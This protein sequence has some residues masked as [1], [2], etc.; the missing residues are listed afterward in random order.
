MSAYIT[1]SFTPTD[2]EKLAEYG[3][4]APAT[5][6]K[7]GGEFL[8]KGAAE[9]LSGDFP[10]KLVGLIRFPDQESARNWYNSEEYQALIPTRDKGMDN[11]FVLG[12]E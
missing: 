5:L 12:V 10:H 7:Y 2:K 3:K 6:A 8:F 9:V 4:S 1:I 11:T